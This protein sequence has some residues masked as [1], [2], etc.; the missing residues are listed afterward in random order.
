[1]ADHGEV[2]YASATGNDYP[3]HENQY[4]TFTHI[5]VLGICL[6]VNIVLAL[7][8]GTVIGNIGVMAGILIVATLIALHGLFTGARI[9]SGVMVLIS[10]LLLAFC[11]YV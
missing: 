1:M 4:E 3:A 5:V 2:Q 8:I 6:V 7:A 11:A 10:I 9:P